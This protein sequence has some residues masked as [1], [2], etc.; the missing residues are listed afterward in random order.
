[1][2]RARLHEMK[3]EKKHQEQENAQLAQAYE[4]KESELK[5]LE[6]QM[7]TIN[8]MNAKQ[9]AKTAD[10]VTGT[11][12]VEMETHLALKNRLGQ[13]EQERDALHKQVQQLQ[14][15]LSQAQE[16]QAAIERSHA[17]QQQELKRHQDEMP[18]L[19][20]EITLLEA[21]TAQYHERCSLA[22]QQLEYSHAMAH[23]MKQQHES[24]KL[25]MGQIK[26]LT[27]TMSKNFFQQLEAAKKEVAKFVTSG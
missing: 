17:S 10:I 23:S 12:L 25:Q 27:V 14:Q 21:Q 11:Q 3:L 5:I 20:Q 9:A 24:L 18:L 8:D 2:L 26:Q 16:A 6:A 7:A 1:M 22:A 4:Q 19:Q 15:E 13:V